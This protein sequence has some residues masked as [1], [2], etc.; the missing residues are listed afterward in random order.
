MRGWEFVRKKL[1]ARLAFA[2][3]REPVC[4]AL[5]QTAATL[6]VTQL[7]AKLTPCWC[8]GGAI[9]IGDVPLACVPIVPPFTTRGSEAQCTRLRQL[10]LQFP[11]SGSTAARLT[12]SG[13]PYP[14]SDAMLSFPYFSTRG[15]KGNDKITWRRT[16]C[17]IRLS[18]HATRGNFE[19]CNSVAKN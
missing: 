8:K 4:T 1:T 5:E 16:P 13:G 12:S 18:E 14:R 19:R 7:N 10:S 9:G 2:E 3:G 17:G 6:N 11:T 15:C